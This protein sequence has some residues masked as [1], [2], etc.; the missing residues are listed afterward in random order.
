MAAGRVETE[1]GEGH[2]EGKDTGKGRTQEGEGCRGWTQEVEG[3]R[4]GR[5][6]GM[7]VQEGGEWEEEEMVI[8]YRYIS[9]SA[10]LVIGI[11]IL[12]INMF[13]RSNK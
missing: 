2:I 7:G 3:H 13:P 9:M 8:V 1:G 11:N 5:A 6:A 4:K 10:L 12:T